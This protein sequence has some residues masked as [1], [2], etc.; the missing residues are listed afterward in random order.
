NVND[1]VGPNNN[2]GQTTVTGT[3][4]DT[5][6]DAIVA[7]NNT[8]DAT[9]LEFD[10]VTQGSQLQFD[11]VFSSEE[12]NEFFNA[13]FND[14]FAFF[15][16]GKNVALLPGTTT[17]VSIDNVTLG[18]NS[19]FYINNAE[20]TDPTPAPLPLLDT[21]MDGLTVVLTVTATVTPGVT[22]HIKLAIA[23]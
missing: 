7:P 17:P 9:A 6:L 1:V 19:S 11:Y 5:D 20:S 22:N 10:F 3:P 15:L 12:Y 18:L 13:S 16:N 4:G 21:Q 23:D 8:F 2:G 14:G